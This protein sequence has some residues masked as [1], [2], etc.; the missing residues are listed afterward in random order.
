MLDDDDRYRHLKRA[1]THL[2][3]R[4]ESVDWLKS[5]PRVHGIDRP[6]QGMGTAPTR[7]HRKQ[8]KQPKEKDTDDAA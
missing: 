7:S 1:D 4:T 2:A 8:P 3:G 6:L 5:T